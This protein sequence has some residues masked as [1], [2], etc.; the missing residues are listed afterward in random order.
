MIMT[1][2]FI[3]QI[4]VNCIIAGRP[5]AELVLNGTV[6]RAN[7]TFIPVASPVSNGNRFYLLTQ[8]VPE[9]DNVLTVRYQMILTLWSMHSKIEEIFLHCH[10]ALTFS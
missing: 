10:Y 5:V 8:F 4:W 3:R 1:G 6:E 7:G 2:K 9:S